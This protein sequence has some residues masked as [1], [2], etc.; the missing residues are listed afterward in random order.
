MLLNQ[1]AC[2]KFHCKCLASPCAA[3]TV[4]TDCR[5]TDKAISQHVRLLG[6]RRE[7][8]MIARPRFSYVSC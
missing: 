5:V 8:W 1:A 2:G 4:L 7:N 6:G 3:I